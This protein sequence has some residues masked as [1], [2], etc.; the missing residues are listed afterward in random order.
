MRTIP[1]A[2]IAVAAV[3]VVAA[4]LLSGCGVADEGMRPGVAAQVAG[5]TI[6]RADVEEDAK[7]RCEVLGE[8]AGEGDQPVSG[9]RV[10]DLALQSAVLREVGTQLAEEY[11]VESSQLYDDAQAEVRGQLD[12]LDEDL[13]DRAVTSLSSTDYFVD[14]LIQ[15]GRGELGITEADDPDGQQGFAQGLEIAQQ[16]QDEHPIE[17]NPRYSG[18]E[19]GDADE[20]VLTTRNDISAAVS[21]YA[22]DALD[23]AE[24]PVDE[25]PAYAASLPESQRC[26]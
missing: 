16:W 20:G 21:D 22:R 4:G 18:I 1:R 5:T 6:D 26:G 23:A 3:G 19:I 7:D 10:R 17:T 14:I 13:I 12:G 8:L 11:D 25:D 15:V 24:N 2:R 9:A